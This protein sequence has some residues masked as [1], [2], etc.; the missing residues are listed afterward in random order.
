MAIVVVLG[1]II[2]LSLVPQPGEKYTEFYI[3]DSTGKT[4]DY[5]REV[6]MGQPVKVILGIVNHEF[7]VVNYRIEIKIGGNILNQKN[8]G[9][10]EHN[11]K[12]EQIVDFVPNVL[13]NQ[14][15]V[16]FHLYKDAENIP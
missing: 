14:Q 8:V 1:A 7:K 12:W 3:L 13:G 15:K 4:V 10:L 16:E 6:K 2:Y 11:Q 5:P 9:K